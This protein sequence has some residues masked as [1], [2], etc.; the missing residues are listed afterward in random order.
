MKI[1]GGYPHDQ[2]SYRRFAARD[3]HGHRR[4]LPSR[5]PIRSGRRMAA[6]PIRV[7]VTIRPITPTATMACILCRSPRSI[8]PRHRASAEPRR[9]NAPACHNRCPASTR[10]AARVALRSAKPAANTTTEQTVARFEK[11]PVHAG[12]FHVAA[13]T[14]S[15][16][17]RTIASGSITPMR[18]SH[19]ASASGGS[20]NASARWAS[21]SVSSGS[22]NSICSI[23]KPA[24]GPAISMYARWC[25]RAADHSAGCGVAGWRPA[26][27]GRSRQPVKRFSSGK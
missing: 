12:L 2:I 19:G 10:V 26:D 1:K 18:L 21:T 3:R 5:I 6:R 11:R 13:I 16:S 25:S 24:S 4:P 9:W 7:R 8:R 15:F 22:G 20:G 17:L 23:A 27:D 14:K